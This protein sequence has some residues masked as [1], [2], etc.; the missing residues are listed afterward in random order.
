MMIRKALSWVV[1]IMIVGFLVN[2]NS[3]TAVEFDASEGQYK[4][5]TVE[6]FDKEP[7]TDCKT[8]GFNIERRV[9]VV[10]MRDGT[11][12]QI[13]MENVLWIKYTPK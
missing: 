5:I 10:I 9:A 12:Y 11:I 2:P 7:L 8:A 6:I 4:D 13:P 1:C 3:A